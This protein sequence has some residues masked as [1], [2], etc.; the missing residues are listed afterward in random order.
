MEPMFRE[1]LSAPAGQLHAQPEAAACANVIVEI[2]RRGQ[3]T[4]EFRRGILPEIAATSFMGSCFTIISVLV[5]QAPETDIAPFIE[6]YLELL[7]HGL[8][9]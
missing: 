6:Q 5:R 9:A 3:R 8:T 4:G 1:M 2:V 7:L